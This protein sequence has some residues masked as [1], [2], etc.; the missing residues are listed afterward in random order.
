MPLQ[1][2]VHM[3]ADALSRGTLVAQVEL[4]VQRLEW[5]F[6]KFELLLGLVERR[7]CL[8]KGFIQLPNVSLKLFLQIICLVRTFGQRLLSLLGCP[9]ALPLRVQH[10]GITF[11][12][13]PHGVLLHAHGTSD[14]TLRVHL[15]RLLMM[16]PRATICVLWRR[17]QLVA[18]DF[19]Q[20]WEDDAI[21]MS[22]HMRPIHRMQAR[23]VDSLAM[24]LV[25]EVRNDVMF[26]LVQRHQS[27]LASICLVG[28]L[29][30]RLDQSLPLMLKGLLG[31]ISNQFLNRPL[32]PELQTSL[33]HV[34]RSP[35]RTVSAL[36]L[37]QALAYLTNCI[38][39][40]LKPV[41]QRLDQIVCHTNFLLDGVVHRS[42]LALVSM[43]ALMY[44]LFVI[45]VMV[46][47][48]ANECLRIL[49]VRRGLG[50]PLLLGVRFDAY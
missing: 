30:A 40:T 20:L 10:H 22:G 25:P 18:R 38:L 19:L 9:G 50:F 1:L 44:V 41:F 21:L 28:E 39:D 11:V 8:T 29:L 45:L 5:H 46:L 32:L 24:P 43:M 27:L 6:V 14:E 47:R 16:M 12:A 49:Q 13:E 23:M 7:L 34:Q 2:L 33:A 26:Q 3:I 42:G 36:Q 17:W 48:L 35:L 31:V 4:L 37:E 15:T